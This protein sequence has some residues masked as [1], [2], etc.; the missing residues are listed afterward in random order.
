MAKVTAPALSFGARGQ[1]G[2]TMVYDVWKGRPYVRSYVIPGNPQSTE[3]T[4]TRTSFSFLQ[5]VYK[6]APT[7]AVAPWTAYVKGKVLTERNAFTKFNLPIL[8][9]QADLADFV[10][11]PGALGG[12]APASVV[13]T[14]GNDQ[15]SIAIA[16]PAVIPDGWTIQAGVAACIKDQDSHTPT[17]YEITADED[18][19]STYTIVLT[20]LDA[21]LYQVGG[22]LRWTRPDGLTA[23]SPSIASSGT[24]T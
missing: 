18:L 12:P 5:A 15:L 23:Y 21:V 13:T 22:W 4:I 3:Q 16:A 24:P 7:L 1:I 17:E 11:S 10:F 14:P 2:K 8:R 20:G 6:L 9:P 19:T